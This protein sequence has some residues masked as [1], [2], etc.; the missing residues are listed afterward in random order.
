MEQLIDFLI[1]ALRDSELKYNVV[2]K[3]V[4]ALVKTLKDFRVYILH[5]HVIAY[6]P[7]SIVKGILSQPDPDGS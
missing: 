2:E 6:V 4:Y 3:Q 5:S 1:M 7:N